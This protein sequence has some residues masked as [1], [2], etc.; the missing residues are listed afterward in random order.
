MQ[1]G[2]STPRYLGTRAF[3]LS[4]GFQEGSCDLRLDLTRTT[5]SRRCPSLLGVLY[6]APL[7]THMPPYLVHLVPLLPRPLLVLF[8][9][10]IPSETINFIC[11]VLPPPGTK[12]SSSCPP[13]SPS[14]I[15]QFSFRIRLSYP[16]RSC[17][18]FLSRRAD[19]RAD[20][21]DLS[22]FAF[23]SSATSTYATIYTSVNFGLP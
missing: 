18:S 23:Y 15:F 21:L 2:T 20:P 4:G 8:H 11:A 12:H 1:G 9:P 17:P 6:S 13:T 19:P 7:S 22:N 5:D 10:Y 16:W 14:P 3:P